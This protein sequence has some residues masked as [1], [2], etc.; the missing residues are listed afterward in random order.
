MGPSWLVSGRGLLLW[1][2][3]AVCCQQSLLASIHG[4]SAG[5]GQSLALLAVKDSSVIDAVSAQEKREPI[6]A[7]RGRGCTTLDGYATSC[8]TQVGRSTAGWR[9][10]VPRRVPT[11]VTP[12]Y[13]PY[14]NLA[15]C[16]RHGSQTLCDLRCDC[17]AVHTREI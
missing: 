13:F 6:V 2:P 16:R 3:A 9:S 7:D 12:P 15:L 4:S 1:Q 11:V 10:L 17:P 8:A 14:F 5:P